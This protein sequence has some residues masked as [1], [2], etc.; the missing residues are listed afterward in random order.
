MKREHAG[1]DAE[2]VF[3]GGRSDGRPHIDVYLDSPYLTEASDRVRFT[4][5]EFA[6]ALLRGALVLLRTR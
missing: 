2:I 6:Q 4:R 5:A 1:G 3:E